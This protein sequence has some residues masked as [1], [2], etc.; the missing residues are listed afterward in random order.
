MENINEHL[1]V[2][3]VVEN[4]D[5]SAFWTFDFSDEFV[6]WFKKDQGLKR[7][8]PKRFEKWIINGMVEG[9][10]YLESDCD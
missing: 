9:V 7:W 5:G 2:S 6:E 10:K 3:E 4:E 8:S 1:K